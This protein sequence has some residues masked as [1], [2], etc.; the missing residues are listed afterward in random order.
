MKLAVM[1][2]GALGCY[3]GGRLAAAGADTSFVARGAHL[4]ALRRDGLR[5]E[6]PLGD[7]HLARVASTDD[8]AEIGPVD[9]VFF[10]VKLYDTEAAAKQMAPL[11]GPETAVLSFQNGVDGW[12]RIGRIVGGERV[13]GG[14]A[15]IPA[16]LAEPGLVRHNGKLAS[17]TIGEFDGRES[18]RL[19]AVLDAFARAGV[20]AKASADIEVA[21]WRKFL[22]LSA[23]SGMTALTRLPIGAIFADADC[24]ELFRRAIDETNAV[25]RAVC[26][27]L[28]ADAGERAFAWAEGFPPG[29]RASMAHDLARGKRLELEHLSG[30]VVRLGQEHGVPTPVHEVILRALHPYVSGRPDGAG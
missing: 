21:I 25:G 23:L 18:A 10:L 5:I 4:A 12:D 29:A 7:L 17:L 2:A 28:P 30:A 27:A 16:D 19:S 22:F 3:F 13:M 14:T 11:L 24:R 6:S 9:L 1:G 8:P 26:P 20:D 15:H